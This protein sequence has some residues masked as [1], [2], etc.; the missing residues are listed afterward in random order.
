MR[1]T[2]TLTNLVPIS[3]VFV[4][5]CYGDSKM[6]FFFYEIQCGLLLIRGIER[7]IDQVPCL[8]IPNRLAYKNN[9]KKTKELQ[10]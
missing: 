7:H 5:L 3:L 9:P 2:L 1:H 6:Y 8:T 4:F 10:R